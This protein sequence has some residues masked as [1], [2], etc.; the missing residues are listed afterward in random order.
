MYKWL[1]KKEETVKKPKKKSQEP[2]PESPSQDRHIKVKTFND[3]AIFNSNCLPKGADNFNQNI[4]FNAQVIILL[5]IAD[6]KPVIDYYDC[7]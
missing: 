3:S 2:R 6:L 7:Y 4:K 1:P 5:V